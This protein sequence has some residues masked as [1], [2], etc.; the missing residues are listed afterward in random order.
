MILSSIQNSKSDRCRGRFFILNFDIELNNGPPI[1]IT[2]IKY[3]KYIKYKD[4]KITKLQ[5]M[6]YGTC[7]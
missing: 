2:Y 6:N 7:T 4:P 1:P 5:N 3:K